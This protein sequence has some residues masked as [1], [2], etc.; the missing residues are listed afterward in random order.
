MTALAAGA[1]ATGIVESV[2]WTDADA[3]LA[4]LNS[5]RDGISD[6]DAAERRAEVGPNAVA[7]EKPPAWYAQL[8]H[9]FAVPFNF[10]L[11]TLAALSGLTGDR[12]ALLVIGLMVL[13]S[14]G[15]RFVQEYRSG[16]AAAALRAMVRTRATVERKGDPFDRATTPAGR[17]RELTMDELAPGDLFG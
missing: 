7:H 14:T 2:A 1:A 13:L 16:K 15:L 6:D 8:G 10:V 9:A 5:S 11:A 3:A 17:R 12:E 4:A